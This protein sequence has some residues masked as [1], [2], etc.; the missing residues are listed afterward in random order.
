MAPAPAG[1]WLFDWISPTTPDAAMAPAAPVEARER[2]LRAGAAAPVAQQTLVLQAEARS[3][4]GLRLAIESGPAWAGYIGLQLSIG[5]R[6]PP[7]ATAWMALVESLPANSEGSTV[8]RDLVRAV[9][10]PLPLGAARAGRPLQHLLA[11][12]W[13]ETARVNRLQA[14][15]W[16]ESAD[17]RML[18]VVSEHCALR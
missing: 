3:G 14:R 5:G 16:L 8:P 9:A 11:L 4:R 15:G 1:A 12:R 6:V 10:G 2:A 17:G 7:G 13:P 18:A